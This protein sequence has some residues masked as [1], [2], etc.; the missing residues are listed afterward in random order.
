MQYAATARV[1]PSDL[2]AGDLMFFGSPIHH[3]A[4]YIGGGQ[5]VEAPYSGQ[6]VRI[7]SSSRSDYV[8]AGRPGV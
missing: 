2:Q 1:A 4:M 7:V 3:V 5:M 8:G 6:S